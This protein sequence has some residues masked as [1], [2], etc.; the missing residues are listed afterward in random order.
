MSKDDK[1]VFKDILGGIKH[2]SN[3]ISPGSNIRKLSKM[4]TYKF[5]P[6]TLVELKVLA[7]KEDK[8]ISKLLD[9]AILLL[10]SSKK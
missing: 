1:K 4:A 3:N 5:H 10:L 6:E 9:E 8:Q 7:A 2:S